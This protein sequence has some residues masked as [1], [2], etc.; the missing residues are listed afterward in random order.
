MPREAT[1]RCEALG[2]LHRQLL[3]SS[4]AARRRMLDAAELL[5]REVDRT[6]QYPIEFISYRLTQW[7]PDAAQAAETVSGENLVADLVNMIQR[8]SHKSPTEVVESAPPMM[9]DG[10]AESLGV[11]TRTLARRRPGGLVMRWYRCQDGQL[12]LGCQQDAIDW[13]LTHHGQ[14][15]TKQVSSS[16]SEILR[17]ARDH[18]GARSLSAL[19]S[20]VAEQVPDRSPTS[21]RGL[22]RRAE[23]RGELRRVR[24]RRL[25]AHDQRLLV[26]CQERGVQPAIIADRLGVTVRTVNRVWLRTRHQRLMEVDAMLPR[27]DAPPVSSLDSEGLPSWDC[28]VDFQTEGTCRESDLRIMHACRVEMGR[29]V[30]AGEEPQAIDAAETALRHMTLCRWRLLKSLMPCVEKAATLWAGRSVG[31]LPAGQQATLLIG[32]VH[33][34]LDVLAQ[35]QRVDLDRLPHMAQAAADKAFARIS[36]EGDDHK[37]ICSEG[38]LLITCESWAALLPQPRWLPRVDLLSPASRDLATQRFGLD[39][40]PPQTLSSVASKTGQSQAGL[41]RRWQSTQQ[42]LRRFE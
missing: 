41:A 12:R 6:L 9:I 32:G 1:F 37:V 27:W 15:R 7:K 28:T 14:K 40:R 36:E 29:H 31:S 4:D 25:S 30:S 21:I 10:V 39:G 3:W 19:A 2:E 33:A 11:S 16:R 42:I 18:A 23:D 5:I 34:V 17:K 22:L 24:Q 35:L 20:Q 8:I 26:R 13:F 38:V